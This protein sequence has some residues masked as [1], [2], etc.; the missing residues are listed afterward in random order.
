METGIFLMG[1]RS[2]LWK[3][4]PDS[5]GW[6]LSREPRAGLRLVQIS[7]APL[8]PGIYPLIQRKASPLQKPVGQICS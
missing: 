5:P 1:A 3:S 7:V 4:R 8:K 2:S 6:L